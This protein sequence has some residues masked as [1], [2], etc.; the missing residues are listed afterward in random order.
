MEF[1]HSETPLRAVRIGPDFIQG[2]QR[3]VHIEGRV[4]QSF[5]HDWSGELLPLQD[6]GEVVHLPI[7]KVPCRFEKKDAPKEVES[8]PA[9]GAG[10]SPFQIS[11]ILLRNVSVTNVRPIDRKARCYGNECLAQIRE[12]EIASVPILRC[13]SGKA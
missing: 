6:K 1:I 7:R 4:F 9:A 3:I 8:G 2:N 10:K 13:E 11:A 12:G 5:G